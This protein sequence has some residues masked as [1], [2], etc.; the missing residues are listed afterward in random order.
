MKLTE[1]Q[2]KA[3]RLYADVEKFPSSKIPYSDWK[4]MNDA[5]LIYPVASDWIGNSWAEF[6][7]ITPAGRAA[8]A[9]YEEA[10]NGQ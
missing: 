6:D 2:A 8:L 3:L 9:A 10:H 1:A 4:P 5:G 7:A